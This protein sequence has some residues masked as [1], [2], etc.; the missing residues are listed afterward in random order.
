MACGAAGARLLALVLL[1]GSCGTLTGARKVLLRAG[2]DPSSA[3]ALSQQRRALQGSSDAQGMVTTSATAGWEL[4]AWAL[5]P[6]RP[7]PMPRQVSR[8]SGRGPGPQAPVY[9][10]TSNVA[11]GRMNAPIV[12]TQQWNAGGIAAARLSVQPSPQQYAPWGP[13]DAYGYGARGYG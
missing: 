3:A 4:D 9:G 5:N 8:V 12:D 2:L 10:W 11:S 13:V 6:S 1:A 7:V